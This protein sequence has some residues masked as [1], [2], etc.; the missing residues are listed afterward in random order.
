M[1]LNSVFQD[2][3]LKTHFYKFLKTHI[4]KLNKY[5]RLH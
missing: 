5:F 4:D 3:F 2:E 1:I